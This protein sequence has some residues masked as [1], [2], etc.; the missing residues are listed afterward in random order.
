MYEPLNSQKKYV[1]WSLACYSLAK[2]SEIFDAS[3]ISFFK[4][5]FSGHMIKH[6]LAAAGSIFII[7][8]FLNPKEYSTR[9]E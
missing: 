2:V 5:I 7:K 9:V 1:V 4:T 6:L 3:I 8:M